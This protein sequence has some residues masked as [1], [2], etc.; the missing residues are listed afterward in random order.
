MI[1]SNIYL[2]ST[3]SN[4][5]SSLVGSQATDSE[6]DQPSDASSDASAYAPTDSGTGDAL[7]HS[8]TRD[9]HPPSDDAN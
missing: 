9:A 7:S 1:P 4:P 2:L 8:G 3:P 5:N 6:T